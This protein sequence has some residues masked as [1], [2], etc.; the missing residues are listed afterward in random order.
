MVPLWYCCSPSLSLN[1]MENREKIRAFLETD[2][3]E[4]FLTD[5]CSPEEKARV[6]RYIALYPEVRQVYDEMQRNLEEYMRMYAIRPPEGTKQRILQSIRSSG[7]GRGVLLRYAIAASV[8]ILFGSV[9]LITLYQ[10]NQALRVQNEEFDGIIME[11]QSDWNNK[12]EEIREL[13]ILMN[14][15]HTRQISVAGNRKERDLKVVAYANPIKKLSYINVKDLPELPESQCY[16]VWT[17]VNGKLTN[18][19]TIKTLDQGEELLKVPYD[20]NAISFITVEAVGGSK[21][22]TM[23]QK[24]TE[25]ATDQVIRSNTYTNK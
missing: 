6:E 8:A 13:H 1:S 12:L 9:I 14:N 19:G 11:M 24:I 15:P 5:E 10:Q 16:Q 3:L 20:Q 17:E 22:P 25:I 21:R 7:G 18:L 4:R 2:L 23:S